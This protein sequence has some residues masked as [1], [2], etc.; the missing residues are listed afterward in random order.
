MKNSAS[1]ASVSNSLADLDSENEDIALVE[2]NNGE[3]GDTISKTVREKQPANIQENVTKI[4]FAFRNQ[5][6]FFQP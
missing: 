6:L 1:V 4:Y 2:D 3:Q 5:N